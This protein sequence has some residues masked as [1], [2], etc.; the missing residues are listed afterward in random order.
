M[1]LALDTPRSLV[2]GLDPLGWLEE[3]ED[4]FWASGGA[5]IPGRWRETAEAIEFQFDL[6]GVAREGIELKVE[7]GLMKVSA[8]RQFWENPGTGE[9]AAVLRTAVRLP[10]TADPGRVEA[11]LE[12]G[13]LRVRLHKREEARARTITVG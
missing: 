4:S 1:K 7:D 12:L 11:R 3:F 2:D 10:E 6:P 5:A 8:R 13:V 9:G